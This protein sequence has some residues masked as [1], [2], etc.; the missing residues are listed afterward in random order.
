MNVRGGSAGRRGRPSGTYHASGPSVAALELL[1]SFYR[2]HQGGAVAGCVP[3]AGRLHR[4]WALCPAAR[5][6]GADIL[7]GGHS[8]PQGA[9]ERQGVRASSSREGR[10]S[11]ACPAAQARAS[12][13]DRPRRRA[14]PS[15]TIATLRAPPATMSASGLQCKPAGMRAGS[16]RASRRQVVVSASSDV[17]AG[18][19]PGGG[20]AVVGGRCRNSPQPCP[21]RQRAAPLR[22]TACRAR[23]SG[24]PIP[25]VGAAGRSRAAAAPCRKQLSAPASDRASRRS[26]SA[27]TWRPRLTG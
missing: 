21:A 15:R 6:L 19:P 4:R 10:Q 22:C 12:A 20:R 26:G 27:A 17:P 13:Q 8:S 25:L 14:S 7:R 23:R 1:C 2:R 16:M 3:R 24:E 5:A 18:A 9:G 11:P